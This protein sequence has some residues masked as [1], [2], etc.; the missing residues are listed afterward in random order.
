LKKEDFQV[1]DNGKPQKIDLFNVE[2]SSAAALPQAAQPLPPGIFTN[3]LEQRPGTPASVTIILLDNNNT[4][5]QNQMYARQQV[6]KYL[7][8][9]KPEDRIGIYRLAGGLKVLHNYTT[10]SADL[11]ALLGTYRGKDIPDLSKNEPG[12]LDGE[13]I[14]IN[15]WFAGAGASGQERDFYTIDRVKGTLKAI[16]FIANSMANLPGRKNLIWVSGGFPLDINLLNMRDPTRIQY[17]FSKE[18]DECVRAVNNANLAIYPVDSRGL[19][20]DHRFSAEQQ[21]V[22]MKPNMKAPVGVRN[23]Q[24]MDE[25]AGRT[26]G[27]AYYNT[28]DLK[29]AITDAVDDARVVYTLGFYPSDE[30]FDGKFHKLEV[31][32]P[33]QSGLNLRYRKG[34]FDMPQAPVDAKGAMAEMRDAVWS[35]LDATAAGIVVAAKPD[36]KTPSMLNMAVQVEPKAISLEPQGDRWAGRLDILIIQKNDKGQVFNGE[37][38]TVNLNLSR[39]NYDKL[40]KHG[41]VLRKTVTMASQATMVRVIVRDAPSGTMGSVT[42]PFAQLTR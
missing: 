1:R 24:T 17:E 42:I 7:Q 16:E 21:K 12:A 26:G 8:T 33:E 10:D 15:R 3:E 36:L 31:K 2:S 14:N 40:V 35:P 39:E 11:V 38:D 9:I 6:L 30:A 29:K 28:N 20:T 27:R 4:N 32:V 41:F 34:Y 37:D 18:I 19:M 23:Q 22:D 5:L 13:L 25:L